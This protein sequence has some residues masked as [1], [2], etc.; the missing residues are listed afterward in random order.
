MH[1]VQLDRGVLEV[2]ELS[3][4]GELHL[5]SKKASEQYRH[6][7]SGCIIRGLR[8][9]REGKSIGGIRLPYPVGESGPL[10]PLISALSVVCGPLPLAS[11]KTSAQTRLRLTTEPLL[12]SLLEAF[13]SGE[14]Q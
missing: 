1:V 3:R 4:R 13:D 10:G 9:G 11:L 12:G 8:S 2:D 7:S 14:R 5:H 6:S